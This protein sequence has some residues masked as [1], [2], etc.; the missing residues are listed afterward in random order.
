MTKTGTESMAQESHARLLNR[1]T[2]GEPL[3][4]FVSPLGAFYQKYWQSK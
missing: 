4:F 1:P 3:R 2:W